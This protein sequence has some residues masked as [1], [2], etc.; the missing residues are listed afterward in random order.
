MK[1]TV[2]TMD[3]KKAGDVDLMDEIFGV[4]P[5]K[6]LVYEALKMQLQNR[7][8]GDAATKTRSMI[9]GSTKKIYRQKGT[10]RARHSDNRAN[11]F[12]GGGKSFG[13]HQRDYSYAIPVKARRGA[14]RSVLAA[15]YKDGKVI[16]VDELKA[17]EPKTS[18][19]VKALKNLG[20]AKGLLVID[21]ADFNLS[22]SVRNIPHVK[23]INANAINLYDV[24][25][26]EHL[27]ITQPAL[28]RVQEILKP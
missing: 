20:V 9:A 3:K 21:K 4:S 19:M 17:V 25:R 23:L 11:I 2:Y 8:Q 27:V 15:K 5:N 12:V 16:I 7:R 13:P 28:M 1:E 24:L 10:G 26:H 18:V 6:A 14:L 22:R